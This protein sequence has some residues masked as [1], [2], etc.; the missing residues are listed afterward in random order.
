MTTATLKI[1]GFV[2]MLALVFGAGYYTK[3][4]FVLADQAKQSQKDDK[5]TAKNVVAAIDTSNKTEAKIDKSDANIT[6]IQKV[7]A[8]K[9]ALVKPKQEKKDEGRSTDGVTTAACTDYSLSDGTVRLLNAARK[10]ADLDTVGIS[11]E[12]FATPSGIETDTLIDNDLEIVKMYHDLATRH[13]QLVTE[14]E[15]ELK[16]R[17]Q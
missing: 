10:G 14:V 4:Q 11:D 16:R 7:V 8:K 2:V 12:A 13:D 5:Q 17:A 6:A 1:W 15:E 3:G 9:P